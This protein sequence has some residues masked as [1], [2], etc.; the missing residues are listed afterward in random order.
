MLRHT[1]I[2][3]ESDAKLAGE[4]LRDALDDLDVVLMLV[5]GKGTDAAEV[6]RIEQ[7]VDWADRLCNKTQIDATTNLRRVVWVRKPEVAPVKK[8][9]DPLLG[10]AP[11]LI[12]VLN[13][14]DE[15][16]GK[17]TLGQKI[18]PLTMEVEFAKG[19]HS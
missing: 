15:V 17:L 13:F 16:R 11:P 8:I 6:A 1:L 4:M 10:A 2:L 14:H 3:P 12:A 9:L 19:H 5:I 7:I 18:S